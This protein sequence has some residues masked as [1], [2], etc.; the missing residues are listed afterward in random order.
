MNDRSNESSSNSTLN[1]KFITEESAF[2]S[3]SNQNENRVESIKPVQDS[4]D[5][6]ASQLSKHFCLEIQ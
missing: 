3:N 1:H 4:S 2:K 6:I 5:K